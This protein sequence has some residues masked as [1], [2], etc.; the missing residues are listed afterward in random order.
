MRI[1]A[2]L[3]RGVSAVF[4]DEARRRRQLEWRLGRALEQQGFGEVI[5]PILDYFTPYEALLADAEKERLYR[6][7]DR[8]GQMLALRSDFTPLLARLLAPRLDAA[9]LRDQPLRIFYRGDV[10]RHQES[11]PNRLRE[12]SQLGAEVIASPGSM[13]DAELLEIL[14]DVVLELVTSELDRASSHAPDAVTGSRSDASRMHVVLGY[15]GAL[16]ELFEESA[17]PHELVACL[18]RR[19][20]QAARELGASRAAL[21]LEIIETGAPRDLAQLGECAQ[22][23]R[24]VMDTADLFRQR[25]ESRGISVSVDLAEFLPLA[26]SGAT[27]LHH[28]YYDGPVFRVYLPGA[29]EPLAS[30]GRYDALFRALGANVVAAGFSV[31]LDQLLEA[32]VHGL[33]RNPTAS[34]VAP[35]PHGEPGEGS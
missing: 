2:G 9:E 28:D 11:G 18:A 25:F 27:G 19:D 35:S 8:D 30:G 31:G 24:E 34:P 7:V 1:R 17:E 16:K 5:L 10:V 20:R 22:G 12:T 6:F 21:L 15:A 33:Q 3:P 13:G 4:Y 26:E 23:L 14:L 32:S 29:A